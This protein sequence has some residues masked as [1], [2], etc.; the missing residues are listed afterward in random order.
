MP[1]DANNFVVA[2]RA[3]FDAPPHMQDIRSTQKV[4]WKFFWS[5]CSHC[6]SRF[7]SCL[8]QVCP[9]YAKGRNVA[10]TYT[11]YRALS[12]LLQPVKRIFVY[13]RN[14]KMNL[15]N[16]S[17]IF[18]PQGHEVTVNGREHSCSNR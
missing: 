9:H 5:R 10:R 11:S 1:N 4:H 13:K 17:L 3:P 7:L 8:L 16:L 14:L 18:L 12:L 2:N 6:T 15:K